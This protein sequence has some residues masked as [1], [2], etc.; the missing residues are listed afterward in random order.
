MKRTICGALT[1]GSLLF[2]FA[3]VTQG[4]A[5]TGLVVSNVTVVSPERSCAVDTCLRA[6]P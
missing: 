1:A 2:L 3:C 5:R 6:Y 4:S